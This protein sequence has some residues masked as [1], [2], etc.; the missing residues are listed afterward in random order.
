[1][2]HKDDSR[3][4]VN[5]CRVD[6]EKRMVY[7]YATTE[8]VDSYGT[9]IDLD[10]VKKALPDYLKWRNIREM[11]QASAVGTAEDIT[12]DDKG[13]YIGAHVTDNAAWSKVKDGVYKGFSIGAKKDYQDGNRLFI[14]K[15]NEISLADRP[16]NED[17]MI[18]T[19]RIYRAGVHSGKVQRLEAERGDLRRILE[20]VESEPSE[21]TAP[22]VDA[23]AVSEKITALD[24]RIAIER[25]FKNPQRL[26]FGSR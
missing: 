20:A 3:L 15:I 21:V 10:S 13:L 17:C 9:V 16:S 12:I 14:A 18:D 1:M 26:T 2:G 6:E 5:I 23:L 24:Q 11:H 4:F 25:I 19:F 22:T 8:A 7:G